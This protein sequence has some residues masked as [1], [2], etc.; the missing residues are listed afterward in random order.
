MGPHSFKCGKQ[1]WQ[2][3]ECFVIL[4]LQWG[5]TLSSAESIII[6]RGRRSPAFLQWGRT[7]SSA[8]SVVFQNPLEEAKEPSMGP[9]SFKCGKLCRPF[10]ARLPT[11]SSM[12]P[13]SFKCGKPPKETTA[14]S[15]FCFLQWGRTLSSA[16]SAIGEAIAERQIRSSMGPHSFKCGKPD[17]A[18]PHRAAIDCLQWGR[19]LSSAE[20]R[21]PPVV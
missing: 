7:L 20:R 9:H 14:G 12:G 13:H 15:A 8:E 6:E 3:F 4:A 19:T 2:H 1:F 21:A 17:G 16:E 5:R 11:D 10:F 18:V